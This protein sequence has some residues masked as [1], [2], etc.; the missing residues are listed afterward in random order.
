M[1]ENH[2]PS[3][4]ILVVDDT[5][6]NR[7]L[8][9]ESLE[10]IGYQTL[11]AENGT[12]A[13]RLASE[14]KPDLILLDVMMPGMNGYQVC[15]ELKKNPSTREIPVLF[16][17][18]KSESNDVVH[19]LEIGGVDYITK[20]FR[21]LEVVARVNTWMR[22]VRLE[23][24]REQAIV[25]RLQAEHWAAVQAIT[26][27]L[28]HNFNNILAS[29][30][31]NLQYLRNVLSEPDFKE[32]AEESLAILEKAKSLIQFMRKYHELKME[33]RAME[34]PETIKTVVE[35]LRPLLPPEIELAVEL[36]SSPPL[37]PPGVSPYLEQVLEAVII[38]AREAISG[39]GKIFI[40][41]DL[42]ER[43]DPPVLHLHVQDTGR[44]LNEETAQKAFLP[45][46][47]TKHTV[48]V[49]LGLYA[50]QLAMEQI[51]G[52][53]ELRGEPGKGATVNITVSLQK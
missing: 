25:A 10:N 52:A 15:G 12:E 32:A 39:P 51:H 33:T 1:T 26:E 42:P 35:R 29:A 22:I 5:E 38:N 48:G 27:G 43:A 36:P 8:L 4:L 41:A 50:A 37:L 47:S 44:G 17:T 34:L 19:G 30:M 20:P 28:A 46:F 2:S 3:G 16:I 53:I 24:E 31:G 40:S 21:I 9:Q 49:G 18:A 6:T 11:P 45:F 13:L 23:K 14:N 7:L